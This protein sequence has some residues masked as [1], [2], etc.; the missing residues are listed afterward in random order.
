MKVGIVGAGS[1]G[2]AA[3]FAMV[4]TGAASEVVIVDINEKLA[5]AQAEDVS[6]ATPFA[7]P[8]RVSA[9]PYEDLAG[10]NVV[11]LCCGAGQ[12]PGETRL[13]LLQRNAAIFRDVVPRVLAA[14]LENNLE[15]D[16]R[17]RIPAALV[18]YF[19]KS[20]LSFAGSGL[21]R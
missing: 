9:G 2:G 13:Q 8:A 20:H 12:R 10:A 18:P 3:A 7:A 19:G 21:P 6:H 16:G 11:L 4:L 17:V 1:V 15:A 14:I 5:H